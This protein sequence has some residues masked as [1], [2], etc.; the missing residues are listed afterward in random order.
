M[1]QTIMAATC[2]CEPGQM[3]V[4]YPCWGKA[5]RTFFMNL[6][7]PSTPQ[8]FI[9]SGTSP[10]NSNPPAGTLSKVVL[11]GAGGAG[12]GD[13]SGGAA[14]YVESEVTFPSTTMT[15]RVG[16]GGPVDGVSGGAP[17]GGASGASSTRWGG[18][19]SAFRLDSTTDFIAGGGGGA[20]SSA[21][22]SQAG[23]S[24]RGGDAGVSASTRPATDITVAGGSTTTNGGAGGVSGGGSGTVG[25]LPSPGTGGTGASGAG[26]GGGGGGG[27]RAAGGGGGK[28]T[29]GAVTYG[30]AGTGGSSKTDDIFLAHGGFKGYAQASPYT[31][32]TL[33]RG[34]G[35]GG[36]GMGFDGLVVF[37]WLGCSTC[38]CPEMPAG[39]P[40]V[41]HI[42]LTQSQFEALVSAAGQN[43][44][45]VDIIAFDYK[46]WPFYVSLSSSAV[47]PPRP[48]SRVA[49]SSDISGGRFVA[50]SDY[51]CRI[52][53]ATLF[54][55]VPGGAASCAAPCSG[56]SSNCVP[57]IFLCDKKRHELGIP[58]VF[59]CG[60]PPGFCVFLQYN[61]C[62]YLLKEGPQVAHC[63][64]PADFT[65][66]NVAETW[67]YKD[68]LDPNGDGGGGSPW[69]VGPNA[70]NG[71]LQIGDS[72]VLTWSAAAT[73]W[74]DP[75]SQQ[76]VSNV[77][78]GPLNL[79]YSVKCLGGSFDP[80]VSG[81][82]LFGGTRPPSCNASLPTCG[83][84][85]LPPPGSY[86]MPNGT[87]ELRGPC[88]PVSGSPPCSVCDC[89][90][91]NF[92]GDAYFLGPDTS[93]PY[94][95]ALTVTRDCPHP[96]LTDGSWLTSDDSNQ[97][98]IISI[99][100]CQ[101]IG[102]GTPSDFAQRINSVLSTRVT[103]SGSPSYWFGLRWRGTD[104]YPNDLPCCADGGG[105]DLTYVIGDATTATVYASYAVGRKMFAYF[106]S[107]TNERF[108]PGSTPPACYC[109]NSTSSDCF[110][111]ASYLGTV[112]QWDR[113]DQPTLL[114]AFGPL[115]WDGAVWPPPAGSPW[116]AVI[117]CSGS[118][119]PGPWLSPP[120]TVQVS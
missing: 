107:R 19:A 60:A 37:E 98:H 29:V 57:K 94:F 40:P 24:A 90:K 81:A 63:G 15:V 44:C 53:E 9:A 27:G 59:N 6:E 56:G 85:N 106:I 92:V 54:E 113:P 78:E 119:G 72:C 105:S 82:T 41:L 4:A 35:D 100:G 61:G 70:F 52:W 91:R 1:P 84:Q 66:L 47:S 51:C 3:Y 120:A 88:N 36:T 67:A 48:C 79:P 25:T 118:S 97:E 117:G 23:Q 102:T 116:P 22:A 115:A 114:S 12:N 46:D 38:P 76:C 5:G 55:S 89:W 16:K 7:S 101:F 64:N 69:T 104:T 30:G 73:P 80:Q 10:A 21:F 93:E 39:I 58:P 32:K 49:A 110:A 13:D 18:G 33:D 83:C 28:R 2:C 65:P 26:V 62:D 96:T 43:T 42:C 11:I 103:A 95:P 31:S 111:A 99:D 68:C 74:P 75:L 50:F 34:L 20:G 8:T 108:S 87:N 71:G 17:F 86:C 112:T 14:A 109:V 77:T 45:N